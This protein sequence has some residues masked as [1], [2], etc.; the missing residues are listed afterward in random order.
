MKC[1]FMLSALPNVWKEDM[2]LESQLD[3]TCKGTLCLEKTWMTKSLASSVE[4]MV[5]CV[6]MK[7]LCFDS[8]STMD[9]QDGVEAGGWRKFLDE[10][11][12]DGVPGSFWDWEL[13]QESIG[14][15][16]LW[17]GSHTGGA[18]LAVVLNEGTEE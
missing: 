15:V 3:A 17:L 8:R 5:S 7:T 11:H 10:V 16:M 6:R 2:N 12:G 4:V 1:N 14:L 13:L 18:G 9:D